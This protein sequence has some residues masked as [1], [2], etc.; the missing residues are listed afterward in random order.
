[1]RRLVLVSGDANAFREPGQSGTDLERP[2]GIPQGLCRIFLVRPSKA[3]GAEERAELQLKPDG[4]NKGVYDGTWVA[5]DHVGA[6]RVV[7][8]WRREAGWAATCSAGAKLDAAPPADGAGGGPTVMSYDDAAGEWMSEE[9]FVD[10][11]AR[12]LFV[13][14]WVRG[15]EFSV[16]EIRLS[17]R[18][19]PRVVRALQCR[20]ILL[21]FVCPDTQRNA[22]WGLH[23][24]FVSL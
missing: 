8:A 5:S 21:A 11:S 12:T 14:T 2:V 1:M 23:V 7:L 18:P 9:I 3:G 10:G 4:S 15:E 19:S 6:A 22:C 13:Q 20:T 16:Q 24:R 17:K